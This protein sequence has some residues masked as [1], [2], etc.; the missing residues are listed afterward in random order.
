MLQRFFELREEIHLFMESKGKYTTELRDEKFLCEMS[1]LCDITSHLN[2]M[3]LQL[4]G[5]GRVISDLYST[6]KAFKTKMSL[7]E[8]QMRKENLS[9]F[10]SC[11]TM[12]EK[13]STTV[14]PTAQFTDKLSMLAA[15]FRRRFADFEAQKV[16]SNCSSILLELMWK[17]HHQTYKWS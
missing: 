3:N 16:G 6:V 1:F 5:W 12:K 7:W 14:F 8:T 10:P 15:D 9:Q 17:A 11:Q 4:Q 13:L 2:E